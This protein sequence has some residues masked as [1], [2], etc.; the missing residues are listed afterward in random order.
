MEEKYSHGHHTK[1]KR[2]HVEIN[3]ICTDKLPRISEKVKI[4]IITFTYSSQNEILSKVIKIVKNKVI[5]IRLKIL[6]TRKGS[7]LQVFLR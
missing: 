6:V 7:E 3:V 2:M 5:Y 4:G 1:R